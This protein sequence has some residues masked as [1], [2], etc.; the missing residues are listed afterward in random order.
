MPWS[1]VCLGSPGEKCCV[2]ERVHGEG[3][4]LQDLAR[5]L[6]TSHFPPGSLQELQAEY[7]ALLLPLLC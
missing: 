4:R 3:K 5:Y 6:L 1:S 2:S 7:E